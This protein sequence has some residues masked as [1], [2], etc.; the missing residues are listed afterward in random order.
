MKCLLII[1]MAAL[2][3]L[4]LAQQPPA[5]LPVPPH[6]L[7]IQPFLDQRNDA[8]NKWGLCEGDKVALNQQHMIDQQQLASVQARVKELEVAAKARD[9]AADKPKED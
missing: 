2:P 1:V 4:A 5:P 3:T 7:N 9:P 6:Q 8:E